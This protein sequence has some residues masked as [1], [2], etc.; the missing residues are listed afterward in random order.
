MFG[1]GARQIFFLVVVALIALAATQIVPAYYS[2]ILFEDAVRQEVKFAASE[3]KTADKVRENIV[4]AA[5]EQ[6]IALTGRDVKITQRGPAFTVEIDYSVPVNLRI[7]VHEIKRHVTESG[8]M[9]G[10]DHN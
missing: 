8:E 6:N 4:A 10:N 2:T 9:F 7:F 5:H 1:L 3:H